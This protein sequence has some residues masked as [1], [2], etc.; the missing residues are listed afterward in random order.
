MGVLYP[1]S[2]FRSGATAGGTGLHLPGRMRFDTDRVTFAMAI[3]PI[4]DSNPNAQNTIVASQAGEFQVFTGPSATVEQVEARM[5]GSSNSG[6]TSS[7]ALNTWSFLA[8]HGG[9]NH[10]GS[11]D[12]D[13]FV[14]YNSEATVTGSGSSTDLPGRGTWTLFGDDPST[15][16]NNTD[17]GVI[18]E[19]A[20]V[21]IYEGII[22][23]DD[24]GW[25]R[26]GFFREHHPR[27]AKS[28]KV[29]LD[30]RNRRHP[31]WDA[32]G[33]GHHFLQEAPGGVRLLETD[34][35]PGMNHAPT[36]RFLMRVDPRQWRDALVKQQTLRFRQQMLV[37]SS[38]GGGVDAPTADD[39]EA[40][41]EVTAPSIAQVN[42]L[43]ADD[44]ES[45]SEV[46]PPALTQTHALTADDTES[47]SEVTAPAISESHALAADDVESASETTAPDL[48]QVHA[49]TADDAESLS[50]VTA[51]SIAQVQALTAE[52]VESASDLTAPALTESNAL[53]ADD[54]ES[55]SEVTSPAV[56]QVHSLAAEDVQ[57]GSEVTAP[58][59]SQVHAIAA[60][61]AESD[62]EVTSPTLAS[63]VDHALTAD[64]AESGSEVTAPAVSQVHA[65]LAGDAESASEITYP[66]LS[67]AHG[68]AAD[69]VE[70]ASSVSV[71]ALNA[72]AQDLSQV[73]VTGDPYNVT[74]TGAPYIISITGAPYGVTIT[75]DP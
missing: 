66:A 11:T 70:S 7:L 75:G 43:T 74:L 31:G 29:L 6:R 50:E 59:L 2:K 20:Y 4:D 40:A 3:R 28:C 25:S 8:V 61:D 22:D 12:V 5:D 56:S 9:L 58:A 67:Q 47:A 38:A 21:A 13:V 17:D 19:A 34:L 35:P 54:V 30:G 42:G 55:A 41:S 37:R 71:P 36:A 1:F 14:D 10:D 49:I 69:D 39:V 24:L 73:T 33:N 45:G 52:D 62:S 63:G 15:P 64:D 68:L 46:T 57:S 51:P 60:D 18:I 16:G 65:L 27:A 48:A 32:S 23:L 44:V 53:T 26:T 72:E